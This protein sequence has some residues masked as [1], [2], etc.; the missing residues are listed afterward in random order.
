[1]CTASSQLVVPSSGGVTVSPVTSF[2][3][4]NGAIGSCSDPKAN[5]E[6]CAF[7]C[8]APSYAPAPGSSALVCVDGQYAYQNSTS[9]PTCTP[10]CAAI[11]C[12]DTTGYDTRP[13]ATD[14]T[15]VMGGA[16]ALL[17]T[18]CESSMSA[19][20]MRAGSHAQLRVPGMLRLALTCSLVR[21]AAGHR[22]GSGRGAW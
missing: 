4:A 13:G 3:P 1:V 11:T 10:T 16:A 17:S 21:H 15:L 5:G 7:A 22:G 19:H 14:A 6:T 20:S 2:V 18:C 12:T 9:P 8:Q